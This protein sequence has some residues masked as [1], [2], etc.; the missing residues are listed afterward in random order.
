MIRTLAAACAAL[1]LLGASALA[2]TTGTIE[3][4]PKLK[5]AATVTGNLVRIGDLVEHAGSVADVPIFRSPDL[6]TTG[7]VSTEAVVQAVRA[8]ALKWLDTA[9]LSEVSVTRAART[10]KTEDLENAIAEALAA[11]YSLGTPKDIT[12]NL[13]SE[14]HA[15]HVQPNAKGEPR[16][17]RLSYDVRSSR[18][19]ATL[20]IPNGPTSRFSLR[21]SGRATA[22]LEV[23]T[24]AAPVMRGATLKDTDILMVRRPRAG[25]GRDFITDRDKAVGMA[26]RVSLE[27]GRPLRRAE[28]MKPLVVLRNEQ[29]T[30][31]YRIPG[32][33]L[34]V[35]GKA[36]EGG[37]VGD[38]ITVLNE[39]SKRMIQG[40]VVGPGQIIV[41]T[42]MRRLAEN[43]VPTNTPS[44]ISNR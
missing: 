40:V 24:V 11:K 42:Q 3:A 16:V 41:N 4:A 1:A 28:L 29:V 17:E 26:A 8:H 36:T 20:T 35:L 31:I 44:N 14:L 23:A 10:F 34:T 15:L 6:G 18:F 32:I 2:Q 7:T 19:A 30:L 5:P 38:V 12:L 37:A 43:M 21:I 9:G 33:T 27:P 39:Q 22:T 25:L 13:D